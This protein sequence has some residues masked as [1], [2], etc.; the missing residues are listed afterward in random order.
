MNN[1]NGIKQMSP[2]PKR[3]ETFELPWPPTVNK[4]YSRNPKGGV[5]K[6]K[7]AKLYFNDTSLLIR[8][9]K[10]QGFGKKRLKLVIKCYP[11]DHAKRDLDNLGKVLLDTMENAELFKDDEQIDDLR[12]IRKEVLYPGHVEINMEEIQ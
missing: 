5:Y 2:P 3:I 8:V 9:K 4:A 1:K 10:I 7:E 6:T 12:F 11:P